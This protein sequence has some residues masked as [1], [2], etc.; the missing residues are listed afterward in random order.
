VL[1]KCSD[2]EAK[3]ASAYLESGIIKI[4]GSGAHIA[5]RLGGLN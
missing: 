1:T 3:P 5:P 2:D 4:V